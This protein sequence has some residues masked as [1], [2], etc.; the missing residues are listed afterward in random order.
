[1]YGILHAHTMFSIHDSAQTPEDLVLRAKE[2]GVHNVTLTDHGTMLGLDAFMEA[3]EKHGVN[4]IP[5]IEMYL[6]NREH[7]LLIARD[8]AGYKQ[9]SKAL[10]E[11]NRHQLKKGRLIF[12]CLPYD[13]LKEIFS[14]SD[15]VIATSACIAG[16]VGRVL[17]EGKRSEKQLNTLME[18]AHV[19]KA[20]Y[21][22]WDT[23]KKEYLTY[24]DAEK[25]LKLERKEYAAYTKKAYLLQ[26]QKDLKKKAIYEAAIDMI[27][28]IDTELEDV[29][30]NRRTSKK[31][32]DRLKNRA[33]KYFKVIDELK[34]ISRVDDHELYEKAK[35]KAL[36]YKAIF[37]LFYL[38]LQNHGMEDENLVMQKLCQISE[39]TGIPVI[40][41]NDAHM[42]RPGDEEARQILRYN[43]F[44]KH[45]DLN[46]ADKKL[47][48]YGEQDIHKAI[49]DIVGSKYADLAVKNTEILSTC[50]VKLPNE[51][52]Y[53]KSSSEH[54]FKEL[55]DE[56]VQRMKAAHEWTKEHE[57]R[58]QHEV[59]VIKEMGYV[60][61]HMIV[62]DYCRMIRTL[63]VVP[64]KELPYM[65]RDFSKIGA[66]IQKK[67]FRSG[68]VRTPGRGSAAGSLV[69][70]LLQITNI[71][72]L[73]YGLLFDR[74]LN[75]ER[76]SMPDIDTDVKRCLRPYII[77]YLKWKYGDNAICSIMTQNMYGARNAIL[78]A[79]RDR[80]SELY[81]SLK[82]HALKEKEYL[83]CNTLKLT[84][85][86]D[87][88]PNIHLADYD[89]KFHKMYGADQ[90]KIIIWKRAKLIEGKLSGTGIHAGGVVIADNGD[91]G[92]YVPLAWQEEKKVWA[93]QCDM[94][95]LEKKG[96]LKMD[97]LGL[98]TQDVNSEALQLIEKHHGKLI[99]LDQVEAEPEV[100]KAIFWSGR[101]NSVF[102]FES[103]GM[104][105]ML[106]RFRPESIEDLILL[107]AM[108]RPG[109][110]QFIDQVISVKQG[111]KKP[112]Y[113]TEEL[114]PILSKTY[115]AIVYQE[116]V[117]QIFQS[118]AGYSLGQA[119][120]VRKAMSKKKND[121]LARE[122]RAFIYGD[123]ARHI[124]GCISKGIAKDAADKIFDEMT[125]FA[126]YAF[127]KSHA[128]AYAII[129]Y[130]T[131]WLKHHYPAEFYCAIMNHEEALEP[132]F[133]DC[134]Y[135]GITILPP[136]INRSYYEFTI[137]KGAIRYGFSKIKGI[138]NRTY[139][140]L[141]TKRRSGKWK[142]QPYQ[143]MPDFFQRTMETSV[144]PKRIVE[145][146]IRAGAFDTFTTDRKWLL[147]AC[148]NIYNAK[149]ENLNAFLA[150]ITHLFEGTPGKRDKKW[151]I[152]QEHELL[153]TFLSDDPFKKYKA[154]ETYGCVPIE[155]ISPGY[156][157]I[158]GY[159]ESEEVKTTRNGNVMHILHLIGRKQTIDVCIM[160]K[161]DCAAYIGSIVQI[162]GQYKNQTF[163]GK[164]IEYLPPSVSPYYLNLDTAEK[165][166]SATAIMNKR[167][168][169]MIPLVVLFHYN[170]SMEKIPVR[171]KKFMVT[172]E[173][174]K[175]VGA[176]KTFTYGIKKNSEMH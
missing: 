40:A 67:G 137:E 36:E 128:A 97:L 16:P 2:L 139:P 169:G 61:Y 4:A 63:S 26:T 121:V 66:W 11:A 127:N 161:H 80:A 95:H 93:S 174:I 155:Q 109:P 33:D 108:Y 167:T 60:E 152:E 9:I 116:Q 73:K 29:K 132:V 28:K 163:W 113:E 142:N 101:T 125:E 79:G 129:S 21:E 84:N 143:S 149:T 57:E 78:M 82:E 22:T 86:F 94:G 10:K 135:D 53:P 162:S 83:H 133:E 77:K 27:Q 56:G 123:S 5:G 102:Q 74:Y 107:V 85:I 25:K 105:D 104:K 144:L 69:C 35:E 99:D 44:S 76:V 48:V 119:D 39:E 24:V 165:T 171:T 166:A 160:A 118:L 148:E 51:P 96:L 47:Y 145:P 100:F 12:P 13:S 115:G 42:A 37:P 19:L 6:E 68:Y 110:M 14:G 159:L 106:K 158:M 64:E 114:I 173:T 58:L 43:Y 150:L 112:V 90:E 7:F 156:H 49:A 18:K 157:K 146:L 8:Y 46:E 136:C 55:I 91:I 88:T 59:C 1:M 147:T 170:K 111:E 141:I 31:T 103:Q 71:D 20:D 151:N 164:E 172:L 41:G 38:E 98:K 124:E 30:E 126:K 34:G 134:R 154:E 120:I 54:T 130:Q 23:A 168:E 62:W 87:E 122:R 65:P 138:G 3:G 131:A 72:P 81:G 176:S 117:M 92:A 89:E 17:L 153:G 175:Q 32:V 140:D 45:Q 75:P 15:H 70:Y 50:H 52:H